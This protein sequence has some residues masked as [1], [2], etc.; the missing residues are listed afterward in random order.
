MEGVR[1]IMEK[2]FYLEESPIYKGKYLIRMDHDKFLFPTGTRGSYNVFPA[3][4]LNLDYATYLR[5]VRDELG[6]ELMGKNSK[7][8]IPYFEM[9]KNSKLLIK[10][11]NKRME[12]IMNEQEFPFE[13]KE[14]EEGNIQRI[15]FEEL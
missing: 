15:P 13:Y 1:D 10:L 7:Y 8:V 2:F 5:Y 4:V 12:Y 6:A 9:D 11:L 3:R 14:D